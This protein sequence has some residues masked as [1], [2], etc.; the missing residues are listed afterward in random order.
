MIDASFSVLGFRVSFQ[1]LA[2]WGHAYVV[3]RFRLGRI[4]GSVE[5]EVICPLFFFALKKVAAGHVRPESYWVVKAQLGRRGIGW[6][7][8]V[9]MKDRGAA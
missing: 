4:R 8:G 1:F 9:A 5:S 3:A 6:A 7:S 2:D